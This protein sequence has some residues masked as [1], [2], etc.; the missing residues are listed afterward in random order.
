MKKRRKNVRPK[1]SHSENDHYLIRI[2]QGERLYKFYYFR[3]IA[4]RHYHFEYRILTKEKINGI[5]EMVS[6]NFK[7]EN[8]V[9][10]KSSVTRVPKISKEQLEEIV[11]NVRIK[12]NTGPDEFEELD[13]SGFSTIDEQIEFLKRRDRVDTM[14]IM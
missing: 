2:K 1:K 10:Q 13:L 6:Y 5:L 9:P 4:G 3:P 11:Q 14:Y 12:T 7:I 8:G